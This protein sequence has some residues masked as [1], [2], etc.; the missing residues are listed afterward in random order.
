MLSFLPTKQAWGKKASLGQK[1]IRLK[2]SGSY[3]DKR[4]TQAVG[5]FAFA[6]RVA[7]C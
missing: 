6:N 5:K 4:L 1:G 7:P 2:H 3:G